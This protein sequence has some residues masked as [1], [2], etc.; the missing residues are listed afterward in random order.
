MKTIH[1]N[2]LF[3]D[4]TPEEEVSV[5][6]GAAPWALAAIAAGGAAFY[7]WV[8]KPGNGFILVDKKGDWADPARMGDAGMDAPHGWAWGVRDSGNYFVGGYGNK[9]NWV[10]DRLRQ[11]TGK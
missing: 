2:P 10:L 7:N 4:I 6:G 11:L 5:Q 1:N 8:T 3:T 9:G